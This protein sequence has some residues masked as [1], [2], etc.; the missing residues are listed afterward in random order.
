MT[1]IERLQHDDIK[2]SQVRR[3]GAHPILMCG[4]TCKM[5]TDNIFCTVSIVF[6]AS[7]ADNDPLLPTGVAN[8]HA[9]FKAYV[10]ARRGG[11]HADTQRVCVP[12]MMLTCTD[13]SLL[14]A[15]AMWKSPIP[16]AMTAM[17]Q[18]QINWDISEDAGQSDCK[19]PSPLS[20]CTRANVQDVKLEWTCCAKTR[21]A[22]PHRT[23]RPSSWSL[24][25]VRL[26]SK[27]C[28]LLT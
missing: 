27:S 7:L 6:V 13:V 25:G 17:Q 8:T 2:S 20:I 26:S 9:H 23:S 24:S 16:Q 10:S 19:S 14:L 11:K 3:T 15:R 12:G 1:C 22:R 5:R 18:Q 28:C 21:K 4:G